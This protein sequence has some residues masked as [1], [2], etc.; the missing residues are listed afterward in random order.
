MS[1]ENSGLRDFLSIPYEEL[2][3]MNLKAREDEST[4]N[5]T[6]L[7]NK[8]REYLEKEKRIKAVTLCFSD[9]E[10]RFHMLDFDKKYLLNSFSNLTF[11]GSSVK[12][13]SEL[14]E[15]D[16][17]LDIDWSSIRWVPADIFGSGKVIIFAN[18]LQEDRTPY[19]SDFRIKLKNYLSNLKKEK[20]IV[21]NAAPEIE[22]FLVEGIN[23]EERFNKIQGFKLLSSSGYFHSLPLDELRIFMDKAAE[24]QRALGFKNEKDHAEVAPSQFEL[25]F[26]YG[27]MIRI[28]DQI[29]LY[30]LVCRQV[31]NNLGMTA[32]FLPKP[33]AHINGNGMHFNVSFQKDGKNIFYNESGEDNFSD[34]GHDFISKILNHAPELCLIFNPSVNSYRRLD[35]NFEA[36]NQI[37]CSAKD[38]GAMIR[39]PSANHK[40]ARVEIRSIS[41][42]VN[43]YLL[44]YCVIRTAM[45]G[46]NLVKEEDKRERLRYLP[47][48]IN[49]ALKIFK[50]SSFIEKIMGEGAKNKY[51]ASKQLAANRSPKELGTIVKNSEILYHHEV[52]NQLLWNNF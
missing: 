20:G 7:E 27:E 38:R 40:S 44:A 52:T 4:I 28:C 50:A 26:S 17:R 30:K 5:K 18:A 48:T 12:G 51:F 19:E 24:A 16:L 34:I 39:I 15:S 23:A 32:T 35:P 46:D 3:E 47:P 36:P 13:F 33:I 29:Q 41:P 8:Y 49:E 45:E 11:D 25:N 2:E 1:I 21:V 9:I 6:K 22:G 31:A 43:P 37:K 10:G 14:R 42:D